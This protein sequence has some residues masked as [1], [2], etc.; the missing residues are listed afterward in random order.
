MEWGQI[1]MD[2]SKITRR[3]IKAFRLEYALGRS[4][5]WYPEKGSVGRKVPG[6]QEEAW[7]PLECT[8]P[9]QLSLAG[10][11]PGINTLAS[12]TTLCSLL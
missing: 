5:N 3:R 6:S 2:L 10:W 12:L 1:G 8:P 7:L 11:E 4:N 9:A